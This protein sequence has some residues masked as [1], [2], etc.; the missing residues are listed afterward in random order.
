VRPEAELNS[1]APIKALHVI[2]GLAQAYGGPS[3]SVPRLCGALAAEAGAEVVL[4]TV[5]QGREPPLDEDMAGFRRRSFRQSFARVPLL[6]GLRLSSSMSQALR[7]ATPNADIIHNHG[8]WLL[9]NI[10]SGWAARRANKPLIISPRGMLSPTALSFSRWKKQLFWQLLQRGVVHSAACI[11]ATSHA[12]Y[13]DIRAIGL[14]NPVAVIPNGID[15]PVARERSPDAAELDRVVLSLGRIHPK[16]GLDKLLHAW[17]K[18]APDHPGWRLRIAGPAEA[19]HDKVLNSLAAELGLS[20]VSV[21]GPIYGDEKL[22]AY[23]RA[24]LFVL[25]T[26]NENFGLTVAESLAAGTPAISTSGAPWSGLRTE[27]CGWWI[28]QGVEPLAAAL[29]D[30]MAMPKA[31]LQ[32]MG[33]KGRAWMKRDFSWRRVAADMLGVY[34]WLARG[35]DAPAVVRLD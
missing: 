13:E 34:H 24:D 35:A 1:G 28:D 33:L 22:I 11:H 8:L 17:A 4:F 29:A 21:E 3:Y 9:P 20:S 23:R 5:A 7:E 25:P 12:E 27:S 32:A 26:L 6:T 10:A 14:P 30:A 15:L 16:K 2:P 19:D 18:V 31:T